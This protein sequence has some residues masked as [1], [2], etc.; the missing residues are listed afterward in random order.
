V[1]ASDLSPKL[2]VVWRVHEDL[3]LYLQY[4]HGFRAP[5]FEDANIGLD[6]PL[7]NVRALPNPDLRSE[8]SRGIESGLRW[9]AGR[10]RLNLSVFRTEYDDF[11]ETKA[12]VG[13]D[14]QSGRL[15]FQSINIGAAR[16]HG[17]EARLV[18]TLR[19]RWDG[20]SL[21]ASAYLARGENDDS[22]EP[23]NSVG[24]AQ[25][26]IGVDWTSPD[27]RT[28]L[29]ALLSASAA[30]D[31]RDQ[32]GGALFQPA[33]YAVVDLFATRRIGEHLRLSASVGNLTDRTIWR[34]A[35]VRSLAP[36][37]PVLPSLAAPGR[38]VSVSLR[39]DW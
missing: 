28:R 26:V 39:W 31:D 9:Y 35:Q 36:D 33:G 25:A 27:E 14:P 4:A 19:E 3:D 23:L 17:A 32:T 15:L 20:L 1:A 24:P 6:I 30:F 22:G 7:F 18:H 29:S 11:I 34:W 10:T 8:T 21:H 13:V 5:P 37:D 38:H 12:R 2:G 16:I